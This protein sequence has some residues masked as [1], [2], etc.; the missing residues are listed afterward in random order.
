M[1]HCQPTVATYTLPS[2]L[3]TLY[4]ELSV[5]DC[6]VP[7]WGKRCSGTSFMLSHQL[8]VQSEDVGCQER[9][10]FDHTDFLFSASFRDGHYWGVVQKSRVKSL[11]PSWVKSIFSSGLCFVGL[12]WYLFQAS[13]SFRPLALEWIVFYAIIS[14]AVMMAAFQQW[15]ISHGNNSKPML[16][17]DGW[18]EQRGH[19]CA[20]ANSRSGG[21]WGRWLP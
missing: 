7:V 5:V 2:G 13:Y 19:P 3:I 15:P 6:L 9:V 16:G 12:T 1:L 8:Y 18:S 14:R 21:D 17:N 4:G 10:C 11:N 20:W